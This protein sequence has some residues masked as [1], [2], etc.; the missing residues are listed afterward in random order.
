M[1]VSSG[2]Q[3]FAEGFLPT[4][5]PVGLLLCCTLLVFNFHPSTEA[6]RRVRRPT[7]R[8]KVGYLVII[9]LMINKRDRY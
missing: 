3:P 7:F 6:S 1:F 9:C 8:R 5:T 4:V 2:R